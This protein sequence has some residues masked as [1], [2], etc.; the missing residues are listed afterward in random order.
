MRRPESFS[1]SRRRS[2]TPW[3][4]AVLRQMSTARPANYLV[5][6]LEMHQPG[7]V[8]PVI[9]GVAR[10]ALEVA[11]PLEEEGDPFAGQ[12]GAGLDVLGHRSRPDLGAGLRVRQ[13][14]LVAAGSPAQVVL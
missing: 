12:G 2:D 13:A 10:P 14:L 3:P 5:G 1:T 11:D 4:S 8:G 7:H 9:A 6:L